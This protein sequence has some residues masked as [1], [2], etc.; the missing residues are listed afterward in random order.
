MSTYCAAKFAL[1]GFTEALRVELRH[2]DVDVHLTMVHLS[3][4]NTPL[5]TW[6]RNLM[7]REIRPLAPIYQPE[8]AAATIHWAAHARRRDVFLGGSAIAAM[9]LNHAT[10][11]LLDRVLARTAIESQQRSEPVAPN[12]PD[13][14]FKPVEGDFGAR[15]A[16]GARARSP[17]R[18]ARFVARFGGGGIRAVVAVATA[19]ELALIDE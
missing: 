16:W 8:V 13:N 15:G 7:P 18:F 1:R 4:M 19:L 14:L 9:V 10:P 3:A 2:A 12:Q 6:A 5:Y 17:A 11:G